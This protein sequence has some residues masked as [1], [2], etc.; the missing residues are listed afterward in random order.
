VNPPA[1]S[2][3]GDKDEA[4]E[5]AGWQVSPLVPAI[6]VGLLALLWLL[7]AFGGWAA[8]AFCSDRGLGGICRAHVVAAVRPSSLPAAIAAVLAAAALLAPLATRSAAAA[9]AARM[10]LL[11]MSAACLVM[12]LTV[13]FFAGQIA[14]G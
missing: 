6:A 1:A 8:A 10:R 9:R 13:L 5:R 4:P 11:S 7:S 3:H 2:P 14:V 12:A